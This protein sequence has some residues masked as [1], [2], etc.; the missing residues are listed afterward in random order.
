MAQLRFIKQKWSVGVY[1]Y[2]SS[3]LE[4]STGIRAG[5]GAAKS[6]TLQDVIL[7]CDICF[8]YGFCKQKINFPIEECAQ[9][10]DDAQQGTEGL[11]SLTLAGGFRRGDSQTSL[12]FMI[13]SSM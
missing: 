11:E 1:S 8:G 4:G 12:L 2:A 6:K 7:C 13:S 3:L 5:S 9:V 10:Q